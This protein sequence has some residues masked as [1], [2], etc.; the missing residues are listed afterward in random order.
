MFLRYFVLSCYRYT[1]YECSAIGCAQEGA[2]SLLTEQ[3][4][5]TL[6]FKEAE[7]LSLTILRQMMEEKM[8][9]INVEMASVKKDTGK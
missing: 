4:K 6:T 8:T 7:T 5:N 1:Q 2:T 3:Y 9:S